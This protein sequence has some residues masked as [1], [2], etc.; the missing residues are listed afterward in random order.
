MWCYKS[1]AS[2][3]TKTRRKHHEKNKI[4]NFIFIYF[5]WFLCLS[6]CDKKNAFLVNRRTATPV[7]IKETEIEKANR[8]ER[9]RVWEKL[10]KEQRALMIACGKG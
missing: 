5:T 9:E 4:V 8:A 6:S 7:E 1:T 10:R 3:K 2:R